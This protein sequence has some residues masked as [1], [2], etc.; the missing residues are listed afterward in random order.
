MAEENTTTQQPNRSWFRRPRFKKIAIWTF[1]IVVGFGV[2]LGLAAPPLIR[3]KVASIL[4]EKFHRPVSIEKIS[5]NPY[6]MTVR[7]QGFLMKQKG[8][9]TAAV[10]FDELYTNLELQSLFRWG[11]V[12]KEIKLTKPYVHLVRG[13]DRKYNFQDIID[14]LTSEPSS[15]PTPRFALNNIEIVDGKIDFDDRPENTKHSVTE[16]NIGVP[17]ISSL[18][19]HVKIKVQPRFSAMINGAPLNLDG[20][21]LPFADTLESRFNLELKSLQIAKYM[22]Y[23]PVELKLKAQSGELNGKLTASFK[24]EK[25][26]SSTLAI[27]G[28]LALANLVMDQSAGGPLVKLQSLEVLIDNIGV[29]AQRAD[30][31]SIT[32]KGLELHVSRNREG[33][34]NLADLA[35]APSQAPPPPTP[36]KDNQPF[37]YII[38]EIKLDDATVHF[39]DEAAGAP[40]KTTLNNIAAKITQFTNEPEKKADIELSFETAAK[41]RFVHNGRLQLE[42]MRADGKFDLKGLGLAALRPYYQEVVA[43]EIR[44]GRL[45][46]QGEYSFAA[47]DP[48]PE[49]KLNNVALLL[50]NLII[51]LPR[52]RES[53]SRIAALSIKDAAIDVNKKSVVIGLVQGS[54]GSSFLQRDTD[55]KLNFER[56]LKQPPGGKPKKPAPKTAEGDWKVTVKQ[57]NLDRFKLAFDDRGA[58]TPANLNLTDLTVSA[59]NFSTEKNNQTGLTVQTRINNQGALKLTGTLGT[60]PLLGKFAV[61]GKDIELLPFQP[62]ITD[63]INFLLTGGRVG[64]QGDLLIDSRDKEKNKINYQGSVQV[65]DLAT[66][67]KANSN[68]LFKWKSLA[69]NDFK[70]DLEPLLISINEINLDEFYSRIIL[71]ADGKINLQKLTAG[72]NNA[73]PEPTG[74]DTAPVSQ[75]PPDQPAEKKPITIGKINLKQGNIYFSDLFVKPNYSANLTDV[76]GA[77]SELKP[78]A[79]GDIDLK[80]RLDRTAPVDIKGKINPLSKEL[81]LE[82]N[83]DAKEIELSPFSPYSGKYVGYGIEKGKLAF[84]VQYKI[85]NRKLSGE[86]KIILNQLTFGEKVDSPEATKLPVTLAISLLKDR[87]GIIDV[88][89]PISGSLDDPQFS[90][91]GLVLRIIINIITKAVTAPF[92]LLGAAFGNNGAELS[93]IEF[94]VGRDTLN[95]GAKT[96]IATLQKALTERPGLKLELSGRADASTD[97]DGL[98]RVGIERKVKAQKLKELVGKQEAAKSVDEV[99]VTKEEYPRYLKAAYGEEKFD[100]PRNLIGFAKDIPVPEME[101]LMFQH[102]QATD[103][104][105]RQLANRRAQVVKDSLLAGGQIGAERIFIAAAKPLSSE[106]Q[107]KLKA[108]PNRVDLTLK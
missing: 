30:V 64:T 100:K 93:Y 9:D 85:D 98:K 41:E 74:K 16:L 54:N 37:R 65:L 6:A 95:P 62:Y 27:V 48:E 15:G 108:K 67:E 33:I 84:N 17:F 89:L 32:A 21:M 45:D 49:I 103:D 91:G 102:A 20:E 51:D 56:L 47:R 81:Y 18:P 5:I 13:D 38:G 76:N 75:P 60:E 11:P 42:P 77:I 10:A 35:V 72:S 70:F 8:G 14:E 25:S 107:A 83:A 87:N 59:R 55:G 99:E 66:V 86:N 12:F 53:L 46:V 94:D 24:T 31:K 104:D 52:Q 40:Y 34:V 7:V 61:D 3:N 29:F 69:L 2:L 73:P 50:N 101:K 57:I 96:K 19:T 58:P 79:P 68:D 22:E 39:N 28:N 1:A 105:L 43:G 26:K 97:L 4:S 78:E 106:E 36:K 90:V 71:G 23:S 88:D 63:Q 44:D 80:A 82:L 92:A